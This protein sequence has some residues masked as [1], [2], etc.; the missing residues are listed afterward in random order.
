MRLACRKP[1]QLPGDYPM[2]RTRDG[3]HRL[4][5]DRQDKRVELRRVL[6]QRLSGIEGERRDGPRRGPENR[7][8]DHRSCLI[9]NERGER[10]DALQRGCGIVCF[11]H[12]FPFRVLA[13]LMRGQA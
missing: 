8:A 4:P 13:A 7:A 1:K 11:G 10:D 5:L 6:A 2:A 9:L 12:C 3:N